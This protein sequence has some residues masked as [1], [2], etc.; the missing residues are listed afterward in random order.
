[1]IF[2]ALLEGKFA[3]WQPATSNRVESK[4]RRARSQS[5]G[6]P[7][8]AKHHN[9]RDHHSLGIVGK[10]EK[11]KSGNNSYSPERSLPKWIPGSE[12]EFSRQ[13]QGTSGGTFEALIG[14]WR[15]VG[16]LL[17]AV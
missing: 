8:L 9:F 6:W 13:V 17:G 15:R 12:R 1:M 5:R 11:G 14:E 16:V 3:G 10:S 7:L 2:H 4:R